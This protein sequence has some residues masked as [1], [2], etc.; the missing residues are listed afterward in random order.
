MNEVGFI[1][2]TALLLTAIAVTGFLCHKTGVPGVMGFLA[3]GMLLGPHG[4]ALDLT[5]DRLRLEQ[6][7]QLALVFLV[8][9]AGL[10]VRLPR[11]RAMGMTLLVATLL[12]V[13]LILCA[14]R[15]AG[16]MLGWP[17]S[18]GW[19]LASMLVVSSSVIMGNCL[20]GSHSVHGHI[21]QMAMGI[22]VLDDV[23]AVAM[24]ALLSF[25]PSATPTGA[26]TWV[27]TILHFLGVLIA[28]GVLALL[29]LPR[30]LQGLARHV[31]PALR[32]W[33]L[34]ALLLG[35][36]LISHLGGGTIVLGSFILGVVI[37]GTRLAASVEHFMGTMRDVGVGVFFV[38]M[39]MLV[40]LG[41]MADIWHWIILLFVVALLMRFAAISVALVL[42]GEGSENAI[43]TGFALAPVGEF[44]LLM[45]LVGVQNS[46]VPSHFYPLAVGVCLLTTLATPFLV[47]HAHALHLKA[48]KFMPSGIMGL[49]RLHQMW[50]E[51]FHQHVQRSV[52][53]K[54]LMPRFIQMGLLV[55]VITGIFAVAHPM[56]A[57]F[58]KWWGDDGLFIQG[59]TI[60][61]WFVIWGVVAA[62]LV[63]LWRNMDAMSMMCAEVVLPTRN[64]ARSA[65]LLLERSIKGTS[66]VAVVAWLVSLLPLD[67]IPTW[68]AALLLLVLPA[69]TWLF[70][71]HLIRWQS[72]WELDLRD[73][74]ASKTMDAMKNPSWPENGALGGE[75][76]LGSMRDVTVQ[77]GARAAG[78]RLRE[79]ELR[80][81]FRCT[82]TTLERQG[83]MI[84]SPHADT[85]IF[86]GDVLL[87]LGRDEDLSRAEQWVNAIEWRSAC[88]AHDASIKDLTLNDLLVPI[89][90]RHAGRSLSD[91]GCNRLFD[92]QIVG[93]QRN[94]HMLLS[95]G[96]SDVIRAGDRLWVVGRPEHA[97]EMGYWLN[98]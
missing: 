39:G 42:V 45:A 67:A 23:V 92:I 3:A 16:R 7:G 48:N 11:L 97:H 73:H 88:D 61:F 72:R 5:A 89:H 9:S 27:G 81:R 22:S 10:N 36:A 51:R 54:L 30:L 35:M 75:P 71:R 83:T 12:S 19:V 47:R 6:W 41:V 63:A 98:T 40:D 60:V 17:E 44:S 56:L 57:V 66:A 28:M 91:L 58:Q 59:G 76:W 46:L 62:P 15:L 78:L 68:A 86:A 33:C 13:F 84:A 8:F 85:M 77:P 65:R 69:S 79:M 52:L 34:S 82:V 70:W 21:G 32:V 29:L 49:A 64:H 24:L 50:R 18:H 38:I 20:R 80:E 95:P 53:W 26:V 87:L 43:K 96:G 4:L 55:L 93:I 31:P 37:A 94:H 74:W 2:E 25:L 14:C 1:T 90:C